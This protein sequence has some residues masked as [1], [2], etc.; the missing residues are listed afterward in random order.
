MKYRYAKEYYYTNGKKT[1]SSV[2]LFRIRPNG[3]FYMWKDNR[4][5]YSGTSTFTWKDKC[6]TYTWYNI[7]LT[8]D[9]IFLELL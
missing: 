6:T 7:E 1:P 4:W 3:K 2:T 5:T 8:K 9:E